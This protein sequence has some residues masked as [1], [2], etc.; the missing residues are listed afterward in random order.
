MKTQKPIR[1]EPHTRI[2]LVSGLLTVLFVTISLMAVFTVQKT[3]HYQNII[4]QKVLE[5]QSSREELS[6]LFDK[7]EAVMKRSLSSLLIMTIMGIILVIVITLFVARVMA[8]EAKLL[9]GQ[10]S[11]T[12]AVKQEIIEIRQKLDDI[13][14][15][16]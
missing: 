6:K 4:K 10:G 8:A 12:G 15:M 11:G 13:L 1:T 16:M 2:I 9:K 3:G 14:R 7:A 5:G